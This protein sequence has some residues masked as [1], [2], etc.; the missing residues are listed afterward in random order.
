LK[1]ETPPVALSI[2]GS[3]PG[4]GAGIQADLKAFAAQGVY[5]TSVI[6]ALTAQNT[7]GITDI[8]AV[9][10]ASIRSQF[11]ALALD[12][13]F[14]AVKT[15]MLGNAAA[16][17]AV[18]ELLGPAPLN[19]VVDPVFKSSSGT[20][21]MDE[22]GLGAYRERLIPLSHIF[23][24]NLNEAARLLGRASIET[25]EA[26]REACKA[27]LALGC[28]AVLLKGGHLPGGVCTDLFY[29]GDFLELSAPRVGTKNT[30]GTGCTLAAA[31]AA[32]L[33]LGHGARESARR[34][35]DYV[36]R[37]LEAGKPW[38]LGQG[39]GPMNHFPGSL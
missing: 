28:R 30:H 4:G 25:V 37:A 7:L 32:N 11:R 9:P 13:P 38:Q 8:A 24:P 3:D 12:L 22:A 31:L 36:S 39:R 35:K 5:G 18:A 26:M 23:T 6:T 33:A 2:A 1:P 20:E 17:E 16:V 29:D 27:L 10:L 21:L 15:G 14:Q 19:L 34:A